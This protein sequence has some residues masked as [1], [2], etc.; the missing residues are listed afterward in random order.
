MNDG[1]ILACA[2]RNCRRDQG[3]GHKIGPN[4][5]EAP[6]AKMDHVGL[7][8]HRT[9][10]LDWLPFCRSGSKWH[11][12]GLLPASARDPERH[13]ATQKE[14]SRQC[15]AG[16]TPR[17]APR[18]RPGSPAGSTPGSPA[19]SQRRTAAATSRT[20]SPVPVRHLA[21][22]DSGPPALRGRGAGPLAGAVRR[23]ELPQ[24]ASRQQQ[25]G[26]DSSCHAVNCLFTPTSQRVQPDSV[27]SDAWTTF[28]ADPF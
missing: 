6:E 21:Q 18:P 7:P 11:R 19:R 10:A 5:I 8:S 14:D 1:H 16:I 12:L 17:P 22:V 25:V 3:R 20:K 27:P 4:P 13:I 26:I 23:P 15:Q 2:R 9:P 28:H 24:V